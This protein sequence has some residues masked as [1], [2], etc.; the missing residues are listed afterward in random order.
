ML[1]NEA[2]PL[3]P[4]PLV[5]FGKVPPDQ[6]R[7]E[8]DTAHAE[9]PPMPCGNRKNAAAYETDKPDLDLVPRARGLVWRALEPSGR[10]YALV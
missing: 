9:Q 10:E 4:N 7:D 1:V 5:C 8:E 2:S 3:G 6:P